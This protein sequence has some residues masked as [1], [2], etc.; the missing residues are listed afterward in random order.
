MAESTE[1]AIATATKRAS[2][3]KYDDVMFS[4][5]N[6]K[7]LDRAEERM[8]LAASQAGCRQSGS[9]MVC[10]NMRLVVRVVESYRRKY[11]WA[12]LNDLVQEGSIGLWLAVQEFDLSRSVR[13][14]TYA[15]W[16][17]REH[18]SHWLRN[19]NGV[20]RCQE[21]Q[22]NRTGKFVRDETAAD[23]DR[24]R[25]GIASLNALVSSKRSTDGMTRQD[26]L[27][28][29]LESA[30]DTAERREAIQRVRRAM[31]RLR[32]CWRLVLRRR[33]ADIGYKEIGQEL[34]CSGSRAQQIELRAMFEFMQA[35][36]V[37]KIPANRSKLAVFT[38]E[39]SA[40]LVP[41]V[42]P[43]IVAQPRR[44]RLGAVAR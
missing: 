32:P 4:V 13:F 15:V 6:T 25:Q 30:E 18:I 31:R 8:L 22:Q 37:A 41:R 35:L 27:P 21:G 24:L 1:T 12:D 40:G 3:S 7:L 36:G 34:G 20:I 16:R 19:N 42:Q 43:P 10:A 2:R 38:K 28:G 44:R 26:L 14:S 5:C 29:R 11:S 23:R 33:A 9:R 17:V 39:L